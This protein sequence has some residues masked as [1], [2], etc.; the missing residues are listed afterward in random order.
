MEILSQLIDDD[1]GHYRF[2][3][4]PRVY[5]LTISSGVFDDDTMWRP[6]LLIP[7]LPELPDSPWTT[8]T[9][10]RDEDGS[11]TSAISTDPL[12]EMQTVWH[13]ARVNVLSLKKK[14]RF[15]S[16]VHGVEYDGEPAIAKV[17]CFNW[18]IARIEHETWAYSILA[19]HQSQHPNESPIAPKFLGHLTENGLLEPNHVVEPKY[20][21]YELVSRPS[22]HACFNSTS[23]GKRNTMDRPSVIVIPAS[24]LVPKVPDEG[25][26]PT[27][28]QELLDELQAA[29]SEGDLPRLQQGFAGWDSLAND[30]SQTSDVT[31]HPFDFCL[32]PGAAAKGGHVDVA[33]Y[34]LDNGW[35]IDTFAVRCAQR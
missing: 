19:R 12:P 26:D 34:L 10:S 25:I 24:Q 23:T 2:Q 6:Y 28:R 18:D 1:N 9:I 16:G 17:A 14:E 33:R 22:Q 5:Y 32:I 8:M 35:K 27:T 30:K 11:L 3:V 15:R 21:H 13:E 7:S 31:N 20:G 4:G 29:A